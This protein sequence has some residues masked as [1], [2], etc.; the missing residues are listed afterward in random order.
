MPWGK[1]LDERDSILGPAIEAAGGAAAVG[2]A[3]KPPISRAAVRQ[4]RRVP[5]NRVLEFSKLCGFKPHQLRPDLYD[6]KGRPIK[7]T[8][9]TA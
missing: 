6:K 9:D 2:R 3:L 7:A 5:D 8:V 4:W 1:E